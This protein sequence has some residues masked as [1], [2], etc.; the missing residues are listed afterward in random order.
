MAEWKTK[1]GLMQVRRQLLEA[2]E[3]ADDRDLHT[4][5]VGEAEM[6]HVAETCIIQQTYNSRIIQPISGPL[7]NAAAPS[8]NA[9]RSEAKDN[10]QLKCPS[11]DEEEYWQEEPDK[12]T[13]E[14]DSDEPRQHRGSW[15]AGCS[16]NPVE[17]TLE[18]STPSAPSGSPEKP[19][20]RATLRAITKAITFV[21][22]SRTLAVHR[23]S[24]L[25]LPETSPMHTPLRNAI[26]NLEAGPLVLGEPVHHHVDNS[27][28]RSQNV[29]KRAVFQPYLAPSHSAGSSP[30]PSNAHRRTVAFW[31]PVEEEKCTRAKSQ[32]RQHR[33]RKSTMW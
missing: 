7:A 5:E 6:R 20:R 26:E 31:D 9:L 19:Q 4:A 27:M 18:A 1:A 10:K 2:T 29:V 11:S 16:W 32:E 30:K 24:I 28:V 15:H 33:A 8:L 25:H 23:H 3:P 17:E 13:R 21:K 12:W 14:G 22:T